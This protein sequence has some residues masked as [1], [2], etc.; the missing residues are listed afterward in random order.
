MWS[1]VNGEDDAGELGDD[2]DDVGVRGR[3][4]RDGEEFDEE[5]T[6]KRRSWSKGVQ[7]P[8]AGSRRNAPDHLTIRRLNP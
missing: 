3:F 7:N 1:T 5:H 4:E 6:E 8:V 2:V